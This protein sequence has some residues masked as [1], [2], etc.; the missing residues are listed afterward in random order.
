VGFTDDDPNTQTVWEVSKAP[1][2]TKLF[3]IRTTKKVSQLKMTTAAPQHSPGWII[4]ED[5][6]ELIKETVNRGKGT[7]WQP[8][9][10]YDFD[11]AR[12]EAAAEAKAAA[13]ANPLAE[14]MNDL[15][16]GWV[17]VRHIPSGKKWHPSLDQLAGTDTYGSSNDDS[18]PWS[19]KFD[20]AV[21]GYDQFLFASGDG[22]YWLAATT[23]AVNGET[24]RDTPRDVI[25]SSL[26]PEPHQVRWYNP[27]TAPASPWVTL[28]DHHDRRGRLAIYVGGSGTFEAG[29][30]E[31]VQNNGG[32][33]VYI[34]KSS[35]KASA[36]V[37]PFADSAALKTA[38]N[39][40]L[41][42]V[43][44]GLDCCKPKSEGGGGADCGAGKHA[45]I[46]DWDTSKV[47]SMEKLFSRGVFN[48]PIGDWDT[49]QVTNMNEMFLRN[50]AFNQPIGDWDT[51]KVTIMRKM[52]AR[53]DAFN[54]PVGSWDTSKVTTMY[55]MFHRTW[56]FNQPI[57]SWDTSKVKDMHGM[58]WVAKVFNQDIS[59]WNLSSR[60]SVNTRKM[61]READAYNRAHG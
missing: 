39:N 31:I 25:S 21:P 47:T 53:C 24:Y 56:A 37:N 28:R 57:G 3:T 41:R 15:G 60:R 13:K 48:Q 23:D 46:G 7:N 8:T 5:G 26:N 40:C 18:A 10:T 30:S 16:G 17:R 22:E 6:V 61:F 45:A 52:F 34:R 33:D 54:Q 29:H 42:A 2:G 19:I 27:P 58:F 20:T 35:N 51:S 11:E 43:P 59:G 14:T 50:A 44:S 4:K 55:N 49:S 12:T 9:Y 32:A 1:V 38:V 36:D